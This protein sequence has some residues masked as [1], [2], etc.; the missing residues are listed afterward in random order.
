MHREENFRHISETPPPLFP[1][2][3]LQEAFLPLLTFH[4]AATFLGSFSNANTP[5]L[6][7]SFITSS[8]KPKIMKL[9]MHLRPSFL[10]LPSSL[11]SPVTFSPTSPFPP[12]PPISSPSSSKE[13][14]K[15]P[16]RPYR[17]NQ[18]TNQLLSISEVI[19]CGVKKSN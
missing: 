8:R 3:P 13:E 18:P 12:S 4:L 9:S 10:I 5:A 14:K 6:S 1:N 16:R 7:S 11:V 19:W 15:K 17:L 2:P